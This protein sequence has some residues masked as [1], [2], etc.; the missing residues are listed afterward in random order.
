MNNYK[1]LNNA[2]SFILVA[3]SPFTA[4]A[5]KL[6]AVQQV[7]VY[8]PD[9]IKIDGKTT[10]WDNKFQAYNRVDNVYYTIANDDD[11]LYLIIQGKDMDVISKMIRGGV[12]FT[13]NSSGKKNDKE[14]VAI[15]FPATDDHIPVSR[16]DNGSKFNVNL[17]NK[18]EITR[19]TALNRKQADSF[20]NVVNKGIANTS[21]FIVVTGI[22]AIADD[23]ISVYNEYGIK[24]V[25]LVDAQINYTYELAIP[26]KYL[27]LSV[28]SPNQFA[29]NI[30]INGLPSLDNV[31]N[32]SRLQEGIT[33]FYVEGGNIVVTGPSAGRVMF[34]RNP[35]DFWGEYTLAK[36]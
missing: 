34:L 18:P 20:R 32:S 10:E 16:S 1:R 12:T 31:P 29:Y 7:S 13:I 24:A 35:T 33:S 9:N 21:K 5:Q 19:D 14:G 22:K 27:G 23:S 30:M 8:A 2:F 28:N 4:N 26:L 36:K 17:G 6:P 15:T 11:R 25:S 3:I